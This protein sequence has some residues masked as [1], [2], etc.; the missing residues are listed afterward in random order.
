MRQRDGFNDLKTLV[1]RYDSSPP[2]P[3]TNHSPNSTIRDSFD[4]VL[5]FG[6]SSTILSQIKNMINQVIEAIGL[7]KTSNIWDSIARV[8]GQDLNLLQMNSVIVIYRERGATM[9]VKARHIGLHCPPLR[10]F[11][12]EFRAC[13]TEGCRP[14]PYDFILRD[15]HSG[16]R[17]TCRLCKWRSASLKASDV[18]GLINRLSS[19]T[20]DVFWHE[21]PAGVDIQDVFV[22]VTKRKELES[23]E[24]KKT[25]RK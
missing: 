14:S 21:Y 17:M 19:T 4:F 6:G 8:A 3:A 5:G 16:I 15:N 18:Q 13:A 25:A 20:P 11:G 23:A 7:D 22:R 9:E 1:E 12:V 10:A 24:A 2:L